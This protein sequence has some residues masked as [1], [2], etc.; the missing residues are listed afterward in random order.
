MKRIISTMLLMLA[1]VS[2]LTSCGFTVPRPEIEE[3]EFHFSVTY[4][5]NGEIKTIFGIYV[6]EYDEP[7]ENTFG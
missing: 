5:F 1:F 2:T 7:I 3:G 4:E 6:C